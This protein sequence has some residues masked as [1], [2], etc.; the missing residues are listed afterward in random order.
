MIGM[1][2]LLAAYPSTKGC[3]GHFKEREGGCIDV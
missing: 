2:K 1:Q 3:R